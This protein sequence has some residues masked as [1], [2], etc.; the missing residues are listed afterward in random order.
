MSEKK[1][2]V[3]VI[4]GAGHIG[5]NLISYLKD[6]KKVGNV[7]SLDNYS[8]GSVDNHVSDI[9]YH[10]GDAKDISKM[11]FAD[12]DCIVHLGEFSRVEQSFTNFSA[13]VSNNIVGTLEV[14]NYCIN[15]NIKL[16]YSASSAITSMSD[17]RVVD[18]PYTIGKKANVELLRSLASVYNLNF[19]ILYFYNVYGP[20]EKGF[21]ENATVVE[22]FLQ[23]KFRNE[24]A[25]ITAPGSQRR[26][27][28]DVRDIVS[29]IY[30]VILGGF[31]DGYY[32][33]NK[34]S[35]SIIELAKMIGLEYSIGPAKPGNRYISELD[36][37]RM[38]KLGWKCEYSLPSYISERLASISSE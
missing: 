31:G 11:D 30:K 5:T 25:V 29:G 10:V 12:I 19:A 18:A 38:E 28:T 22:K 1:I 13:I 3:L 7:Q 15:K 17:E 8:N 33:G 32:I 23:L 34:Q 16:I 4:G 2:N 26:N 14:V 6:C 37:T 21:G 36:T 35:F 9:A 27:F 24:K 20:F